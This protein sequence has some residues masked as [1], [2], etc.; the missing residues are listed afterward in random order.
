MQWTT[1]DSRIYLTDENGKKIAEVLF[2]KTGENEYT[3]THTWVDDSLRG[4]GIAGK[5]MEAAVKRIRELGGTPK[6]QCSYA[7]HW[8]EKHPDQLG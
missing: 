2:P 7:V 8:M 1:E 4:Q 5:L 6:A 3:V